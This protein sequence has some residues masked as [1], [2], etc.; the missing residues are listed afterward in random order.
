MHKCGSSRSHFCL[1]IT[2]IRNTHGEK[3][4]TLPGCGFHMVG[5]KEQASS[6]KVESNG[7]TESGQYNGDKNVLVA[8]NKNI[9]NKVSWP[10]GLNWKTEELF[11][12]T[13]FEI[14]ISSAKSFLPFLPLS[15]T[16]P[17]L[18]PRHGVCD[19]RPSGRSLPAVRPV[20]VNVSQERRIV[21]DP[22]LK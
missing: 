9:N 13:P 10:A 3:H 20:P 15:L 14:L 17:P 11:S 1:P 16:C 4:W 6:S 22:L 2:I 7:L 5:K 18:T 12:H 21:V 19:V 8:I